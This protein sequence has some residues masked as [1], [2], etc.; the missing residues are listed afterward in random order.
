MSVLIFHLAW[1]L[2]G[3]V[4]PAFRTPA[5]RFVLDGNLAV[6]VFFVLSGDAL[7]LGFT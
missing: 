5:L 2:F 7:S 1:E 6:C 3:A 4:V